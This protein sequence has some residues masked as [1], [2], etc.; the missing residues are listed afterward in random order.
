MG[1]VFV[2][3]E[4]KPWMELT[5]QTSM[6]DHVESVTVDGQVYERKVRLPMIKRVAIF[7]RKAIGRKEAENKRAPTS[8]CP[9]TS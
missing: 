4:G 9:T 8:G 3:V 7:H 1:A 5:T 6:E 2:E